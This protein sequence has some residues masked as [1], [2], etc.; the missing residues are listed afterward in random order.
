MTR[1][2]TI[3]K[4]SDLQKTFSWMAEQETGGCPG[5]LRLRFGKP[6]HR[7]IAFAMTHGKEPAG[8]AFFDW[9]LNNPYLLRDI[10]LTLAIG[11]YDAACQ[12]FAATTPEEKAK[13]RKLD[14]DMNRMPAAFPNKVSIGDAREL[15][16]AFDLKCLLG[17]KDDDLPLRS[18]LDIHSTDQDSEGMGID[19][20]GDLAVVDPLM[21]AMIFG[22]RLCGITPV[23][24]RMGTRTQP[25]SAIFEA[26]SALELEASQH[27]SEVGLKRSVLNGLSWLSGLGC[28]RGRQVKKATKKNIYTV[29]RSVMVSPSQSDDTS[30]KLT[31]KKFLDM[32]APV[33]EGEVIATNDAGDELISLIGGLCI[34]GPDEMTLGEADRKSELLW[35]V[36]P[37]VETPCD[38]T[39]PEVVPL[40][41]LDD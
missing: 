25:F 2:L 33:E 5:V 7:D 6:K 8:L 15:Y 32:Y 38:I 17:Q 23:Q 37:K 28:L 29:L 1:N 41:M 9:V 36:S 3:C 19:I 12:Y 10:D 11:N 4:K 22:T 18:V 35:I 34:F 39:M 20:D 14:L 30:W 21:N 26:Q 31:D 27:E 40:E 13:C 24:K 16:R